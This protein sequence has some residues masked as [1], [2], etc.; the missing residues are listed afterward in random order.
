MHHVLA[1]EPAQRHL[2]PIDVEPSGGEREGPKLLGDLFERLAR[3]TISHRL[4]AVEREDLFVTS[5]RDLPPAVGGE[6]FDRDHVA[7]FEFD[8][9]AHRPIR[10]VRWRVLIPPAEPVAR[11]I[12][13]RVVAVVV[14]DLLDRRPDL[15][16]L[17]AWL[18]EIECRIECGLGR[19]REIV[20]ARE[21]NRN[22]RVGE[23]AVDVDPDVEVDHLL[24][25]RTGIVGAR[26]GVGGLLVDRDVY[27]KRGLA[28]EFPNALFGPLREFEMARADLDALGRFLA[29]LGEDLA[30]L[31]VVL[32]LRRRKVHVAHGSTLDRITK[33]TA[34]RSTL[35][36]SP[37][38]CSSASLRCCTHCPPGPRCRAR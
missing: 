8:A 34:V 3:V 1:F 9:L 19:F 25:E 26:R 6:R 13:H 38:R 35:D 30:R 4:L 14:D 18:D 16:G 37:A 24:A 10:D 27:W 12:H 15:A 23:P 11:E 5:F 21:I 36:L 7:G 22:R 31:A 29:H 28:T 2:G 32:V 20:V 17:D 33:T